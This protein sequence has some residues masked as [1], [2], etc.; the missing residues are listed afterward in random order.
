MIFVVGCQR[1]L[2]AVTVGRHWTVAKND[3]HHCRPSLSAWQKNAAVND[4]SYQSKQL[5]FPLYWDI[6][7]SRVRLACCETYMY[8]CQRI[9]SR[10]VESNED[11]TPWQYVICSNA[12]KRAC[13]TLL[14]F[15]SDG[16][17]SNHNHGYLFKKVKEVYLSTGE[18]KSSFTIVCQTPLIR[19]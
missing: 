10:T 6:S 11:A 1:S 8:C 4:G 9:T 3:D 5:C 2:T 16:Y 19:P 7:Q 18:A 13:D 14:T 15:C 17:S 12:C